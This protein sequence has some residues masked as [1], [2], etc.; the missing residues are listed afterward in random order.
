MEICKLG[1]CLEHSSVAR[2][3]FSDCPLAASPSVQQS[4]ALSP[5]QQSGAVPVRASSHDGLAI[6]DTDPNLAPFREH[7]EYQY[8]KYLETKKAINAS[9]GGLDAFSQGFKRFGFNREDGAIVYR[10]WAPAAR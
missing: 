9:E 8:H 1:L 7:L 5:R 4:A 10:E 6:M 3:I 2:G